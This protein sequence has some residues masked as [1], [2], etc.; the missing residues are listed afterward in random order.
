MPTPSNVHAHQGMLKP[1]EG[2]GT[3]AGAGV[4]SVMGEAA[5][6]TAGAW[7]LAAGGASGADA[8]AAASAGAGG[9]DT[10]VSGAGA[11]EASA[12][13]EDS[14]GPAMTVAWAITAG[15]T[16]NRARAIP[17]ANPRRV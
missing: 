15:G 6:G 17:T 11:E 9:A 16:H 3:S 1:V 8:G 13:P 14:K 7:A 12:A 10:P 2:S 4:E 5:G